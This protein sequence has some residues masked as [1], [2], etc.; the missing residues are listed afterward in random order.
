MEASVSARSWDGAQAPGPFGDCARDPIEI[1]GAIQSHG[2][3]LAA[4]PATGVLTHASRPL[5]DGL[6]GRGTTLRDILGA[7][8]YDAL[9]DQDL[10]PARNGLFRTWRARLDLPDG[11]SLTRAV[12]AHDHGDKRILELIPDTTDH[13]HLADRF[14]RRQM[15]IQAI[16]AADALPTLHAQTARFCKEITGFDRIMIYKFHA[17]GHGS[18]IAEDTRLSPRFLDHHFPASDI[19]EPARRLY[20]ENRIRIIPDVADAPQPVVPLGDR[21]DTAPLDLSHATLRAVAPVHIHYLKNM[22]VAASL[23][24]S[25]VV[26]GKLWGL[27]ACHHNTPRCLSA[28]DLQF[29]EVF[30]DVVSGTLERLTSEARLAHIRKS[31]Q[32]FQRIADS[33]QTAS[34]QKLVSTRFQDFQHL[35]PC[36]GI[37]GRISGNTVRTGIAPPSKALADLLVSHDDT[38]IRLYERLP[39]LLGT[40][41][42]HRPCAGGAYM[43][44]GAGDFLFFS[45]CAVIEERAWGHTPP[46]DQKLGP[47]RSFAAW[48]ETIRDQCA[49]FEPGTID[50]LAP[51]QNALFQGPCPDS[52]MTEDATL[53]ASVS[54]DRT[55]LDNERLAAI[56]DLASGLAH[57]LNQPL[58][59]VINYAS[60]CNLLLQQANA[61]ASIDAADT[62][63][64]PLVKT[65]LEEAKRAG[66]IVRRLRKFMQTGAF[67]PTPVDIG[68]AVMTALRFALP[69]NQYEDV[70]VNCAYD[71][72][73]PPVWADDVQIQQVIFNLVRN[74]LD[75]MR[76]QGEKKLSITITRIEENEIQVCLRDTGPGIRPDMMDRVF[77]PRVTTKKEGMGIGLSLSR[78]I[79]EAHGGSIQ[80]RNLDSGAEFSFR[81]PTMKNDPICTNP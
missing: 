30:G 8:Q 35:C 13:E 51:L 5:V 41:D 68:E 16:L 64:A 34:P 43:P 77:E 33:R 38:T 10:R 18:V 3:L 76:G 47:P 52:A 26:Q 40:N 4:D 74:A 29:C 73:L 79:I 75:A 58:A 48:V 6:G 67:E 63:L 9:L 66:E 11:K 62:K 7:A 28:M 53:R 32:A 49:P 71:D 21:V 2:A 19:P 54:L 57:E 17:D 22:G 70:D 27:I 12:I 14:A 72:D 78:S 61:R 36:D 50:A 1:P 42:E 15:I 24:I 69:V 39:H 20:L 31:Q 65:M 45:R 80:A 25:L 44:L 59:S 55:N 56:G 37:V 60:T 81:L 23:S 46:S